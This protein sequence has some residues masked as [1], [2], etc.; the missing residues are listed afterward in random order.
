MAKPQP[1]EFR[2]DVVRVARKRETSLVQI[3]KG[4]NPS[5]FCA[6]SSRIRPRRESQWATARAA[7]ANR[8]PARENLAGL[9]KDLN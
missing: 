8:N 7:L 6:A 3:A 4:C 2:E 9:E 5:G 1:A